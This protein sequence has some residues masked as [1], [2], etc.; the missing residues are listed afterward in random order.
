MSTRRPQS[1]ALRP[2]PESLETRQLLSTTVTGIDIDGDQW[3]LSL[4]GPGDLQ[5]INQ[6]GADGL[7]APLTQ[8]SLINE[9][10]IGGADP[11]STK[12]VGQVVKAAGGDG[13]V[14][15]EKLTELGGSSVVVSGNRGIHVIDMP[16]FYLGHTSTTAPASGQSAAE[17]SIPDGVNNLR[18]GGAD[19]TYTP[20]GGTPLDQNN[21]ADQFVINLG[22]PQAQG[23]SVIANTF[24]SSGQA[25]ASMTAQP[26]QDSITINVVGRIN[27]FQANEIDGNT[28]V[29]TGGFRGQGGTQV[30]SLPDQTTQVNGQIGFVRVGNNAT[31]FAVQSADQVSNFYIGGETN[32]VA[33]LTPGG[34]RNLYFGKGMDTV[35]ILTHVIMTLR[36]NR[37]ALNSQ[38]IS[39]RD[40]GQAIFGGDV[41]NTNVLSGYQQNLSTVFQQQQ[42]PTTPAPA[43]GGGK[44]PA[45]LIA[46]NVVDSVFAASVEPFQNVFGTPLSLKLPGG[47]IRAKVE[48]T[49]NNTNATPSSPDQAF[50]AE[51]VDLLSGPVIPPTVPEAPFPNPGAP[52]KGQGVSPNLQP[53]APRNVPSLLWKYQYMLARLQAQQ[54]HRNRHGDDEHGQRG[55]RASRRQQEPLISSPREAR[56]SER[57]R[58]ASFP[59]NDG[60]RPR[61]KQSHFR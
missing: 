40:I 44:M 61:G 53:T 33:L 28:D 10:K 9:I 50:F 39:D 52:P 20:P 15:F 21:T 25:A 41:V 17:I 2:M 43:Q 5:V 55:L 24:V 35:S 45:V 58:L 57:T 51:H 12:L 13:K 47:S 7:P 18:F 31:N 54:R 38:I 6:N 22:L 30:Y 29:P 42:Q 59:W 32:N 56:R 27:V 1:R 16:D 23:T 26:T 4:I 49:I 46:G 60:P 48:G 37:G 36:A 3:I 8:P 11:Q 34:S 19:T 14:Y